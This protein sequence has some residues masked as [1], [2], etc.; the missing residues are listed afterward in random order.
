MTRVV[1]GILLFVL[2]Q[3]FAYAQS[4]LDT[5]NYLYGYK[6]LFF[7]VGATSQGR[8]LTLGYM[9]NRYIIEF[10]A[11]VEPTKITLALDSLQLNRNN[12]LGRFLGTEAGDSNIAQITAT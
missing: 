8:F 6:T 5:S 4:E 7:S 1:P 3:H 10:E 12:D 11:A 9:P 2:A